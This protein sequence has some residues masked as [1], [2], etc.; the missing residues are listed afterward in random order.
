MSDHVSPQASDQ[1]RRWDR[2]AIKRRESDFCD[3]C[4][5]WTLWVRECCRI[6][7]ARRVAS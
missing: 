4:S 5:E 7:G 6:C 3:S 2:E 1:A